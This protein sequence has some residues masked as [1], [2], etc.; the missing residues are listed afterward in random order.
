MT[1][2]VRKGKGYSPAP[3]TFKGKIYK[4]KFSC[5]WVDVEVDVLDV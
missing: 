2:K 3:V 1:S 4:E 5:Y